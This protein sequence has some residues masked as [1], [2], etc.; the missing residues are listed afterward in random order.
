MPCLS[1]TSRVNDFIHGVNGRLTSDY[2][3]GP[4]CGTK[5]EF[6]E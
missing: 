6:V 1:R 4:D 2:G 3:P 5:R